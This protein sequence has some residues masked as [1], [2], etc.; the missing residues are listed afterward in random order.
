M[1]F[2]IIIFNIHFKQLFSRKI[3]LTILI[4]LLFTSCEELIHVKPGLSEVL[5][6]TR[7]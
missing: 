1:L 6:V 3:Y 4:M 7:P 2:I 5:R